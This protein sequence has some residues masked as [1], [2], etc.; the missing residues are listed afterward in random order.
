MVACTTTSFMFSFMHKWSGF[1]CTN[2]NVCIVLLFFIS[3]S[4]SKTNPDHLCMKLNMKLVVVHATIHCLGSKILAPCKNFSWLLNWL[5]TFKTGTWK[6]H[7]AIFLTPTFWELLGIKYSTS[8]KINIQWLKCYRK[9][10]Q[11]CIL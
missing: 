6:W 4:L 1:V 2:V 9:S 10:V 11:Y 3:I 7:L 8:E 5:L